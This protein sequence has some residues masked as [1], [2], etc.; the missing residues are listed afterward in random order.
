[1]SC[2]VDLSLIKQGETDAVACIFRKLILKWI[3]QIT[4]HDLFM[5]SGEICCPVNV[6]FINMEFSKKWMKYFRT[7]GK[8]LVLQWWWTVMED[9]CWSVFIWCF[10]TLQRKILYLYFTESF[11]AGHTLLFK[12]EKK[13]WEAYEIQ[14]IFKAWTYVTTYKEVASALCLCCSTKETLFG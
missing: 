7:L 13:T 1:M 11:R 8:I 4:T 14:Y 10:I 5:L 12:S 9:V 3:K 6:F 2:F